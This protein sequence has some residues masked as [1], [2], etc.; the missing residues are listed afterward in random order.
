LGAARSDNMDLLATAPPAWQLV[1]VLQSA[2][3]SAFASV[4]IY[5]DSIYA[6]AAGFSNNLPRIS[7]HALFA[8]RFILLRICSGRVTTATLSPLS[9][10]SAPLSPR[11]FDFA[12][13]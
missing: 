7:F 10:I 5:V 6:H 1:C 2:S 3:A 8:T 13:G 4:M 9:F 11:G 12:E